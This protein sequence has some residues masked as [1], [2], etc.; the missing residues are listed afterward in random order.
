M[1]YMSTAIN[2]TKA[3]SLMSSMVTQPVMS[4]E[5]REERATQGITQIEHRWERWILI[6]RDALSKEDAVVHDYPR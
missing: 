3:S 1:E 4:V 5:K 2:V 6:Y